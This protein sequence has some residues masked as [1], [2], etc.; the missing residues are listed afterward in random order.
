MD[1]LKIILLF[2]GIDKVITISY[3]G[4]NKKEKLC[5]TYLELQKRKES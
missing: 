2:W 3:I 5:F 4:I 1:W